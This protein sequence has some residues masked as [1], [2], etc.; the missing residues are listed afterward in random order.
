MNMGSML[1]QEAYPYI[2][3]EGHYGKQSPKLVRHYTEDLGV[4]YLTASCK[5]EYEK[6][7]PDFLNPSSEKPIL[8][9]AF[10]KDVNEN[11]ALKIMSTIKQ[12]NKEQSKEMVK[13]VVGEEAYGILKKIFK[14]EKESIYE[15]CRGKP[16]SMPC[17]MVRQQ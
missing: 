4:I 15:E 1:G 3:A 12:S 14:N 16:E 17:D 5:E 11:A 2:C 10:T 8:L 13:K 7:L 9:E 6:L